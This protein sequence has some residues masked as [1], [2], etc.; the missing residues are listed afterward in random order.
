[1]SLNRALNTPSPLMPYLTN[2]LTPE[3]YGVTAILMCMVLVWACGAALLYG[4]ADY[5]GGRA[6]KVSKAAA[7]TFLGQFVALLLLAI[8][9]TFGNT[10]VMSTHDCGGAVSLVP[11]AQ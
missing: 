9:I 1:M 10:P 3:G 8:V 11:V 7:V 2:T 6:S 5:C 4:V